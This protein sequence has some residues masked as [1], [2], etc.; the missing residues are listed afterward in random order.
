MQQKHKEEQ[1]KLE[2]AQVTSIGESNNAGD[3]QK[4]TQADGSTV[5]TKYLSM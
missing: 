2:K 3:T 5:T 4:R 1:Q